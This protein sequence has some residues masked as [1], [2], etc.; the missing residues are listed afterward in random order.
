M[1]KLEIH[2]KESNDINFAAKE[3][4]IYGNGSI[5]IYGN[6]SIVNET[7]VLKT[8]ER[9][10]PEMVIPFSNILYYRRRLIA[11]GQE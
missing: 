11:D 1:Y 5:T 4:T 8:G 3:I 6:G 10:Y 9:D 2:L 7:I